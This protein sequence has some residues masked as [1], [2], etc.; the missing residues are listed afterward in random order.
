[1]KSTYTVPVEFGDTDPATIVFY[2]HFFRWFDASAWRLFAK[3]G[4]TLPVLQNDFGLVGLPIAE[5]RS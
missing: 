1:M 4:L 3:A 2:P 5:A